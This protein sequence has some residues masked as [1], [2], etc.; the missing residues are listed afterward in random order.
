MTSSGP[1]N[2]QLNICHYVIMS[3]Q[4]IFI[5]ANKTKHGGAEN[6]L[7]RLA[8]ELSKQN[9]SYQIVNSI[10]PR[11]LP[12][13]LRAILFNIQVCL[14]KKDGIYFSLERITCPDIYRA[15]DGVHQVFLQTQE[16]SKLNPLHPVSLY[17]EQH[18]F[19]H[20]KYI[21]ANSQMVK[22]QIIDSYGIDERK[23]SV[24]YNSIPLSEPDHTKSFNKLSS[25]FPMQPDQKI[26]LYVGSGFKRKGVE[27]FL[28]IVAQLKHD[29][30]AFIV[31]KEKNMSYYRQLAQQSAI[32]K[33][34]IFTGARDDVND[35]YTIADIF[36]LPTHYEPFSNVVLEAMNFNTAVFTTRQNGASEIMD[37]D[38]IMANPNDF[39]IVNTINNLLAD[40]SQLHRVKQ[41]NKMKSKQF[42]ITAHVEQT[43]KNNS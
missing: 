14:R 23:I 29:V 13:W 2:L 3:K 26:L 33:R 36:L 8:G 20:A 11:Y 15:G 37:K 10:F 35:F 6:Y 30:L 4:I 31:G 41:E 17:L 25:E 32:A 1:R 40:D 18:C 34:V 9:I 43:L 28:H 27:Q 16:K 7:S 42:S 22:N 5:R 19:N 24:I 21:I 38:Y 12:S 39:S